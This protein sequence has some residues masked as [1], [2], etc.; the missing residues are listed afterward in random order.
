[1]SFELLSQE[2]NNY[3]WFNG[4]FVKWRDAQIHVMT[5]SL[6]YAASVFE[7]ERAYEGEIFKLEEHSERLIRSAKDLHIKCDYSVDDIIKSSKDTLVKNNLSY[8]YLRPLIWY[9]G[10]SLSLGG[11]GNS[12]LMIAALNSKAPFKQSG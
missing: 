4:E 7:G 12:N 3:I 9:S 1:M 5:H 6:H 10:N 8:A 2:N 11:H